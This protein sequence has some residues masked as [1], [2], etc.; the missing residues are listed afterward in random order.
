MEFLVADF[1]GSEG[2]YGGAGAPEWA[3]LVEVIG[4]MPLY[5]QGSLQSGKIGEAI[6]DP[7]PPTLT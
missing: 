2:Y 1:N 3:D 5:L 6:F 7:K 4:K